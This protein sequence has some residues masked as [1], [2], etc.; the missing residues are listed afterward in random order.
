MLSTVTLDGIDIVELGEQRPLR[1]SRAGGRCAELLALELFRLADAA[2]PARQD[3]IRRPVVDHEHRL[4]R[5]CRVLVAIADERVDVGKCDLV[6]C[7][8]DAGDRLEPVSRLVDGH[9]DLFASVV[10]LVLRHQEGRDR[11]LQAAI[12]RE[13]DGGLGGGGISGRQRKA[14]RECM[15]AARCVRRKSPWLPY[16]LLLRST[17][18]PAA[19]ALRRSKKNMIVQSASRDRRSILPFT[20]IR[21]PAAASL[22]RRGLFLRWAT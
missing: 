16:S 13:P 7:R 9:R 20:I 8:R 22:S 5:R 6:A 4:D 2:A 14:C 10:A 12:E 1:K 19:I 11:P 3:R 21:T 17:S 18:R 15:E